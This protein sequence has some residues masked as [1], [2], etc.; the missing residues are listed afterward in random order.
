MNT[1][2][3]KAHDLPPTP[4]T[5]EEKEHFRRVAGRLFSV[6]WLESAQKHR[7]QKLWARQDELAQLELA[8]LGHAIEALH[9]HSRWL[10][11]SARAARNQ[12]VGGH[13]HL[14]EIMMLGGLA[15]GGST[16]KPMPAGTAG[17]DAQ[18]ALPD[19][20]VLRA[21]VKNHDLSSHEAAFREGCKV[22]DEVARARVASCGGSWSLI[23]GALT[24]MGKRTIQALVQQMHAMPLMGAGR[25]YRV[26]E[27]EAAIQFSPL[28][29]PGV[30]PPSYQL[31]VRSPAHANEQANFRNKLV[32]AIDAFSRHSPLSDSYSNVIFMRVHATADV[33]ALRSSASELLR[34]PD[35]VVDAVYF[36]QSSV[37]KEHSGSVISYYLSAVQTSRYMRRGVKLAVMQ[38]SGKLVN[39]PTALQLMSPHGSLGDVT[40]QYLFQRGHLYYPLQV[41]DE[42]LALVAPGP[43]IQTSAV[44]SDSSGTKTVITVR[45]PEDEELIVL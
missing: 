16:V 8:S 1:I 20:H 43:G 7:L 38:L 13:G 10:K 11:D 6:Q 4:T 9:A 14:F 31:I 23:A 15:A 44:I 28:M 19:G 2:S 25:Q 5:K 32:R 41:G 26:L 45:R 35:C 24:H 34:R 40:G 29:F 17:Y 18:I 12:P 3:T 21:S 27:G 30:Q 37:A 36:T 42:A 39:R 22:L 33:D